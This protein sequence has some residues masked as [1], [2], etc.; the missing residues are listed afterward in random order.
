M[1]AEELNNIDEKTQHNSEKT[2]DIRAPRTVGTT[3]GT[4][5]R[6]GSLRRQGLRE[7][8]DAGT[9]GRTSGSR[10]EDSNEKDAA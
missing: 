2:A 1:T 10:F 8:T 4:D 3:D 7:N 5:G 9:T 6:L